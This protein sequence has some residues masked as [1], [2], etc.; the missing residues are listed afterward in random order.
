MKKSVLL[1]TEKVTVTTVPIYPASF[2]TLIARM[3]KEHWQRLTY[4]SLISLAFMAHPET[5]VQ[6]CVYVFTPDREWEECTRYG[7]LVRAEEWVP[8]TSY[9]WGYEGGAK[10]AP[11]QFRV[12][13]D[14]YYG[15]FIE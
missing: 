14:G 4:R 3:R 15:M 1:S 9:V 6:Y 7:K 11:H 10:Q 5:G 2:F 8:R 13:P 12:A